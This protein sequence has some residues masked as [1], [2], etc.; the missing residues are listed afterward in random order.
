MKKFSAIREASTKA[1][2]E[3]T[4]GLI[5]DTVTAVLGA[6]AGFGGGTALGDKLKDHLSKQYRIKNLS[7]DQVNQIKSDGESWQ[8]LKKG[9][10]R[11][12]KRITRQLAKLDDALEKGLDAESV[13]AIMD[14]VTAIIQN[15][16]KKAEKIH[17]DEVR[18]MVSE[19]LSAYYINK[20]VTDPDDPQSAAERKQQQKNYDALLRLRSEYGKEVYKRWNSQPH[21]NISKLEDKMLKH[22]KANAKAENK[23]KA[24]SDKSL[25][26]WIKKRAAL[27]QKLEDEI[28]K[29]QGK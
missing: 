19:I 10:K 6:I 16:T 21:K 5:G 22:L 13:L 12:T 11:Y 15:S 26:I 18:E 28:K 20:N 29:Y 17:Y 3:L 24:G 4:E 25:K 1:S 23:A 2:Q 14:E 27:I 9:D 7:M 8:V